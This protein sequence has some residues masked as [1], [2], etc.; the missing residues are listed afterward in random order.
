MMRVV[1]LC[2]VLPL[3][4]GLAAQPASEGIDFFEQKIRPVLVESMAT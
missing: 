2:S 3:A 1:L 4:A